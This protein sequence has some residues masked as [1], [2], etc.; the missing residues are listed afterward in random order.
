MTQGQ[1]PVTIQ[2]CRN[3]MTQ[4]EHM[5]QYKQSK[6]IKAGNKADMSAVSSATAHSARGEGEVCDRI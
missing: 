1:Q 4:T 2:G 6:Y 3:D 5:W